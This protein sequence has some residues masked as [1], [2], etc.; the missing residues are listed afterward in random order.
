MSHYNYLP[1]N[2]CTPMFEERKKPNG[3]YD[4]LA[5]AFTG[6]GANAIANAELNQD[7]FRFNFEEA[8]SSN[9][10]FRGVDSKTYTGNIFGEIVGQSNGTFIGAQGNHYIGP[11][12]SNPKQLDDFTKTKCTIV[13]ACPS[14]ATPAISDLFYNQ[15]C[16]LSSIRDAD[17][18][19]EIGS[20]TEVVPKEMVKSLR[21]SGDLDAII[22]TGPSLYTV[23]KRS[24]TLSN[25][26]DQ[27]SISPPAKRNMKKRS[28]AERLEDVGEPLD[29]PIVPN[30]SADDPQIFV[31]AEYDHRLMPD[32]GGPIFAF[33]KAKLIQPQW[34]NIDNELIV[35][36]KNYDYLRPGTLIAA[37]ICIEVFVM[38]IVL[39]SN[40]F[41]KI[42]HALITSLKVIAESDIAITPPVPFLSAQKKVRAIQESSSQAA[43]A[44]AAIDWSTPM[45]PL[46]ASGSDRTL[47]DDEKHI[48]SQGLKQKKVK[49][50]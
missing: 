5:H 24:K 37:T 10:S 29:L 48:P 35:P 15:I 47:E 32:F 43:E 46:S 44:L 11:D 6:M 49:K 17:Q 45:T 42:Y 20:G 39:G 13:L 30:V 1:N 27:S 28:C 41:R 3:V 50:Q 36:W 12:P 14:F 4:K 40:K 26:K 16:T 33:R 38:P 25:Q 8:W 18:A 2:I 22:L 21:N 34:M 7:F 23:M 9:Y 31:G 19:E